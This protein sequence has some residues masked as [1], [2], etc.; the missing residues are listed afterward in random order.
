MDYNWPRLAIPTYKRSE[1]ISSKT[2]KYLKSVAYP[3]DLIYLFVIAEEEQLYKDRVSSDLY[4]HIVIGP[5][6]LCAMRNRISDFFDE[7]EIIIQMD[8]DVKGIKSPASFS[9]IFQI[10]Y[11][12]LTD[13]DAPCG[14]AGVL[15]NDDTRR[16][17]NSQTMHLAHI[18]GSFFMCRNHKDIKITHT[19]KEDMERSILYYKRYGRVLRYQNAGVST[20]YKGGTGGLQ[21]QGRSERCASEIESLKVRFPN[22]VSEVEKVKGRDLILNWR[23][24][25][26]RSSNEQEVGGGTGRA[27]RIK[28]GILNLISRYPQYCQIVKK[29]SGEIDVVLKWRQSVRPV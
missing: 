8:D 19:E 16:F 23:V 18:L 29:K 13:K 4:G 27:S 21:S 22:L 24:S 5:V 20:S 28:D 7:G 26:A 3:K 11:K 10:L 9:D 17:K 1:S 25:E 6:G 15:P 14:L 2:L 12:G